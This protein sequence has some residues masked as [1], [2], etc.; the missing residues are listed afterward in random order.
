MFEFT[1][2]STEMSKLHVSIGM[3]ASLCSSIVLAVPV[4]SGA[5]TEAG[6][7][8]NSPLTIPYFFASPPS[9][10]QPLF[11]ATLPDS[12]S[13]TNAGSGNSPLTIPYFFGSSP[14]GGQ[15]LATNT[16]I[17][18]SVSVPEP[19]PM[20]LFGIALLG[21]GLLRYLRTRQITG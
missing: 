12:E 11:S 19:K 18:A 7:S 3:I 20:A 13:T 2:R 9:G 5:T 14:S 1:N 21:F 15:L 8:G 16:A 6:G 17:T 10:G 4:D